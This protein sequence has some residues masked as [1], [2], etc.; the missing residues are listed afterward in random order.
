[1][2]PSHD[3]PARDASTH[4]AATRRTGLDRFRQA[5]YTGENRCLPCAIVNVGI[6]SVVAA[7]VTVLFAVEL[8]ALVFAVSLA[9]IWLRG[10]LVP[11]TP[12][13]TKRYLPERV[14]RLFG[15]GREAAPPAEIDA[16]SYLLAADVLIETPDGTEFAF[17]PWFESAWWSRL[18]ELDEVADESARDGSDPVATDSTADGAKAPADI[19]ALATLTGA[20]AEALSIDWRGGAAY[21]RADGARIG[22]WESR[23]AF[24]ADLAAD[25][26]LADR[27]DDWERLPLAARSG[28]LG[29]LR[30]FVET[31]PTC[32]GTVALEE[33]VVESC[34]A[35]YDV[36]AGR[37]LDCDARLFEMDLPPSVATAA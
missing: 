10:Y 19:A 8:A 33:R 28:V 25:R 14:L 9:A 31:C 1:M 3:V 16:E 18:V 21:A 13:L 26:V 22:H 5:E 30:L 15:K 29:A 32:E 36:V 37:C 23:A 34:C 6:A 17:A 27:L 2:T 24:L 20:D 11:G 12:E 35:S 7:A 4:R